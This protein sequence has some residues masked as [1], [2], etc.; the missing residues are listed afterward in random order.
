MSET[1]SKLVQ[2]TAADW[3]SVMPPNRPAVLLA[4]QMEGTIAGFTA[5]RGK[6]KFEEEPSSFEAA[7]QAT[8]E[9]AA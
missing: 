4:G 1:I 3:S 9:V 7:L 8:K 2:Q 5:E 6:M